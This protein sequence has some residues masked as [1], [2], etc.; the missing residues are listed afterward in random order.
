[1][2]DTNGNP[3]GIS[4]AAG[5]KA[6]TETALSRA[7]LFGMTAVIPNLLVL[8]IRG[9][10]PF[11]HMSVVVVLGLMIPVSFSLFPQ[12]EMIKK[13][14]LEEELQAAAGNGHLFYHRGL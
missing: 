14:N 5:E 3:V 11:H 13:E 2:F 8:L 1:M 6:V 4:K 10:R 9:T 7:A 12:L